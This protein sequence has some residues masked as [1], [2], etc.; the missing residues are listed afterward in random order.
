M[1]I[2]FACPKC[3]KSFQ[4]PDPM[5]GQVCL[6]QAC[7][8]QLR[9]PV[10]KTPAAAPTRPAAPAGPS[11]IVFACPKCRKQF[12]V[13]P[14]M[15]GKVCVCQACQAQLRVPAARGPATA[16]Q[17]APPAAPPQR[18]IWDEL[19]QNEWDQI[20]GRAPQKPPDGEE[21]T[22]GHGP[23]TWS[24]QT[25]LGG[26]WRDGKLLVVAQGARFPERCVKTNQRTSIWVKRR[27]TWFPGWV[28]I[29]LFL[30]GFLPY[31]IAVLILTR[32]VE[33][34]AAVSHERIIRRRILVT[35]GSLG[36]V[37]GLGLFCAM[38]P[39]ISPDASGAVAM[40]VAVVG[41]A[42]LPVGAV[43]ASREAGFG[44]RCTLIDEGEKHAWLKGAHPDFLSALPVW[45]G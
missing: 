35:A 25:G 37:A 39:F 38:L 3:R 15:A 4:V 11:E 36:A 18:T 29:L 6:C 42:M 28:W 32:K 31:L 34:E 2:S 5:A 40:G 30:T 19:S 26:L 10:P 41:I 21:E 33:M 22:Q 17:P 1:T 43:V 27:V 44:L 45:P 16:R 24:G 14:Q 20:E 8:A 9:V 23:G 13:P 7:G 12:R